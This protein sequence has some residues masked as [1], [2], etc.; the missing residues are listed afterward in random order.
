M[1]NPIMRVSTLLILTVILLTPLIHVAAQPIAIAELPI[2]SKLTY[3]L[4]GVYTGV[5]T[6]E[7]L[8]WSKSEGRD[9]KL[10]RVHLQVNASETFIYKAM[11][12]T[13][14]FCYDKKGRPLSE[15]LKIPPEF[16]LSVKQVKITY[17]W[18]DGVFPY[19]TE[20][21]MVGKNE[22]E[23]YIVLLNEGR[24]I[25]EVASR[26]EIKVSKENLSKIL[27]FVP[28]RLSEPYV[29]LSSLKLK[30]GFKQRF[31]SL[32]V[33]VKALKNVQ[34]PAGLIP[35]YEVAVSGETE[36]GLPYNSTVYV[37]AD[38]PRFTVYYITSVTGIEQKGYVI[39]VNIPKRTSSLGWIIGILAIAL[40]AAVLVVKKALE[41]KK[42][43]RG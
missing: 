23:S 12:S 10:V 37:T 16:N 36:E 5:K 38:E 34:T 1:E 28:E 30:E 33:E 43:R 14:E 25:K 3:R 17:W 6:Y 24:V 26:E 31:D 18:E 13:S 41:P 42:D 22:N 40:V 19:K 2:G 20:I 15:L 11:N 9:C 7:V 21:R 35:C 8:G 32:T 39:E 27:P 29:D 4:S